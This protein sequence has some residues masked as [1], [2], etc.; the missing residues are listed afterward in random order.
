MVKCSPGCTVQAGLIYSCNLAVK[1]HSLRS[2]L[3]H[4]VL[5]Y[6]MI[7]TLVLRSSSLVQRRFKRQCHEIL[8]AG[9]FQEST[10]TCIVDTGGKFATRI[11]DTRGKLPPV[12]LIP[13]VLK[14]FFPLPLLSFLPRC[15]KKWHCP[16][17]IMKSSIYRNFLDTGATH[18]ASENRRMQKL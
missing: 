18:L 2:K 17:N 14:I 10:S 11:N 7:Y 6:I 4:L 5:S 1:F 15:T 12:S 3:L 13:V 9:F 16:F 8:A